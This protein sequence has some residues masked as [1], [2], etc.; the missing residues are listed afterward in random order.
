MRG[1]SCQ[2]I[3]LTEPEEDEEEG[4]EEVENT[5]KEASESWKT[6]LV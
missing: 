6:C 4:V 2:H 3:L 5:V 1:F